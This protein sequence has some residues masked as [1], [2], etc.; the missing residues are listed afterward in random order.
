MLNLNNQVI[1]HNY[2]ENPNRHFISE[3]HHWIK[4]GKGT[5]NPFHMQMQF[6]KYIASLP[7]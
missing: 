4:L 5:V 7:K 3:N 6:R 2:L 1:I